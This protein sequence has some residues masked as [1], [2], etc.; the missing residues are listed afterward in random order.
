MPVKA[1]FDKHHR[2]NESWFHI[3]EP[4]YYSEL[5]ADIETE[6]I[7]DK[8]LHGKIEALDN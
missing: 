3:H 4:A 8:S 5:L 2:H 6:P 7:I 1:P